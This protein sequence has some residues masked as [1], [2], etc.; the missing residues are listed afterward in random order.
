[1]TNIGVYIGSFDPITWGHIDLIKRV[2]HLFNKIVVVIADNQKKK[3]LF[4]G[5]Q[6]IYLTK[7]AIAHLTNVKIEHCQKTLAVDIVR[8]HNAQCLIRGVRGTSDLEFEQQLASLNRRLAPEIETLILFSSEQYRYISSSL[9][10]EIA[11]FKQ[12]TSPFV[13]PIVVKALE[14]KFKA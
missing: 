5:Q 10:K 13:P 12:D 9:V 7:V 2:S 11:S 3:P 6:R 14:E 8:K 4:T 1:V